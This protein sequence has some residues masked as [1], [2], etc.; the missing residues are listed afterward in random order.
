MEKLSEGTYKV[1]AKVK[2][3]RKQVMSRKLQIISDVLDRKNK[4][5]L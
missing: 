2:E 4:I 5:E 3:I 1:D